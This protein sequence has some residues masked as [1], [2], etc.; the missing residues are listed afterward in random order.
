MLALV[1]ITQNFYFNFYSFGALLVTI[2]TL[3]L[4]MFF[5]AMPNKSKS[6]FHLGMAF[7]F[8]FFFTFGYFFAAILYTPFAAYHRWLTGGF[9]LLLLTHFG[10][11]FFKYPRDINPKLSRITF[12]FS[13]VIAILVNIT[14]FL[15]TYHSGKKYHFTGH[16]WDFDAPKLSVLLA[17]IIALFLIM[18][19]I[20]IPMWKFFNTRGPEKYTILK[21]MVAVLIAG[22]IPN[23]TNIMS[24]D[25]ALPRSTYLLSLVLF[26]VI[27]FFFVAIF[28]LNSTREKTTFMAKIVGLTLV[29]ILLVIQGWGFY[30]FVEQDEEYDTLHIEKLLGT[31]RSQNSTGDLAYILR[32]DNMQNSFDT[33]L[34]PKSLQLDLEL[35]AIDFKNTVIYETIYNLPPENFRASLKVYLQQTHKY[36]AGYKS[37]L[38]AFL[39][40]KNMLKDKTLK[41]AILARVQTLNQEAFVHSNKIA[42]MSKDTFCQKVQSY[43]Q[44]NKSIQAFKTSIT[45]ALNR[46]YWKQTPENI[47]HYRRQVYKYLRHFKPALSRHYRKSLHSYQKQKHFISYIYFDHFAGTTVEAG[48]SYTHYRQIQHEVFKIQALILLLV[49]LF[50]IGFYPLFFKGS[51]INP[52]NNL[53]Q[54]VRKVNQGNLD[55]SIKIKIND[56]IGFLS[57]S[58]NSMVLS[59]KDARKELQNYTENLEGMV[60]DRTQ[61]VE[62]RMAEINKLKVQQDG[63]YYLTSLLAKP[64]FYNA[65][66]SEMVTTNFLILQKKQFEFRNKKAELGGDVCVTGAIRLG[67]PDKF[68][69]YIMAMN[70]DAMGKSMQGAGGSLVMGVVV[71]SIMKRSAANDRVMDLSAEKWLQKTYN[72]INDVFKTF[73]GTMVISCVMMLIEEETGE[74]FYFNAEHPFSVLY[75]NREASFIET[76]LRL[77]KVGLD[78]EIPF[79]VFKFQ[80]IPGDVVILGSDGRDDIDLTPEE[81][82][83]TIN[84]DETLFLMHV[85]KGKGQLD[86]IYQSVTQMGNLIDDLSLLRI[87]F[88][89]QEAPIPEDPEQDEIEPANN[90]DY[91]IN[92]SKALLAEGKLDNAK[93]LLDMAYEKKHENPRLDKLY[94]LLCFKMKNYETAAEALEKYLSTDESHIDLWYY[95]ALSQKK[96]GRYNSALSCCQKIQSLDPENLMNLVNYADIHRLLGHKEKALELA[97]SVLQKDKTHENAQKIISRIQ[98]TS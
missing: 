9:I 94:G 27:G 12:I 30:M 76:D 14:F 81:P 45:K 87:S 65:N 71:N 80:L 88:Q 92:R 58:F 63:D 18:N 55:H 85:R 66:K 98:M 37:A 52:L 70:G 32:L 11:F 48:F 8:L 96:L 60:K 44:K 33:V 3:L 77:R 61:E 29:S 59:I 67:T 1:A 7:A 23:I 53:L 17:V 57:N 51:L 31:I 82:I 35:V 68:S 78:S 6:T 10:Q 39:R 97:E 28:Y 69:R 22:T 49:I 95:L 4:A 46:C 42:A 47:S 20:I 40:Q 26:F 75:R 64:L 25:G 84:E 62:E 15:G 74:V 90:I 91:I 54:G 38:F 36:F 50:I 72:E 16:Y 34:Y 2:Y 13:Y 79:E 24:R 5:L 41:K 21:M 83:R 93:I 86:K 73:N 89:E 19:F 56:E 43:L